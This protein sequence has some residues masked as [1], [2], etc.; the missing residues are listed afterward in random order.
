MTGSTPQKLLLQHAIAQYA[1]TITIEVRF[2]G[3]DGAVNVAK[4]RVLPWESGAVESQ[5]VD[6]RMDEFYQGQN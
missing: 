3:V 6:T 2:L 1:L 5:Q 4:V